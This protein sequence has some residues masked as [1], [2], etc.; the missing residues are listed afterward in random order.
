MVIMTRTSVADA[1]AHFTHYLRV[2][3]RG[4]RVLILRHG[5]PVAALVPTAELAMLEQ[6]AAAEQPGGLASL[7]GNWESGDELAARVEQVRRRRSRPRALPTG[8]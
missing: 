5:H 7:A 2:T 6:L 3:E 8:R 1:K 4:E